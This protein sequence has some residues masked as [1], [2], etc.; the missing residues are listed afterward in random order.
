[1]HNSVQLAELVG[2]LPSPLEKVT[3]TG[4]FVD[5]FNLDMAFFQLKS[6]PS[7]RDVVFARPH[8]GEGF[9][10]PWPL[11]CERALFRES[12]ERITWKTEEAD[13]VVENRGKRFDT[14]VIELNQ[15]GVGAAS[16][17]K[18]LA[19][20]ACPA[21]KLLVRGPGAPAMAKALKALVDGRP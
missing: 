8:L 20:F 12:L 16:I 3:F 11:W 6:A 10:G 5:D 13:Y 7:V 14:L 2:E 9:G 19:E 21:R 15:E 1:M 17:K 4:H 18:K